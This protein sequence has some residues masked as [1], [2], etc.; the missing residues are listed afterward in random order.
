MVDLVVECFLNLFSDQP[1]EAGELHSR[2]SK[3]PRSPNDKSGEDDRR[4]SELSTEDEVWAEGELDPRVKK[5]TA[6]LKRP[7]FVLF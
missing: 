6:K 4:K 5:V 3:M 2:L 7:S 1:G